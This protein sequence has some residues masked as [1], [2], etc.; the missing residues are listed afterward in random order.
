MSLLEKTLHPSSQEVMYH[1]CRTKRHVTPAGFPLNCTRQALWKRLIGI[2][3]THRKIIAKA[4]LLITRSDLQDAAGP[5]QLCAWKIT[6]IESAAHGMRALYPCKDTDAVLLVD[7][8]NV[9]NSL[10]R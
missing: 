10:N 2:A 1:S 5:R 8:T 9:I 3:E 4:V 7:A 6:S